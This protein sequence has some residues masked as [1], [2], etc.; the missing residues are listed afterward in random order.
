MLII[1]N[2]LIFIWI[3]INSVVGVDPKNGTKIESKTKSNTLRKEQFEFES[4]FVNQ[5][6]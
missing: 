5:N 2:P 4:K 3:I 6:L 1:M